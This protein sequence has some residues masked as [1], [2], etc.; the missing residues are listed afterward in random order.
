MKKHLAVLIA[1]TVALSAMTG[2]SCVFAENVP[3]YPPCPKPV[4]NVTVVGTRVVGEPIDL[5]DASISTNS[6]TDSA[7]KM[8]DGNITTYWHSKYTAEGST[9]TSHDVA[10]FCVELQLPKKTSISGIGYTPR[11]NNPAGYWKSL[12]V[13]YSNDGKKYTAICND[14]YEYSGMDDSR[15]ITGFGRNISAK[16]IRVIITETPIYC[17]A[18]EFHVFGPLASVSAKPT[19][20]TT[21]TADVTPGAGKVVLTMNSLSASV[22][23]MTQI[24]PVAPTIVGGATMVPLQ[25]MIEALGGAYVENGDDIQVAYNGH[26]YGLKKN[27]TYLTVDTMRSF[28]AKPT[29]DFHGTIMVSVLFF[30]NILGVKAELNQAQQAIVLMK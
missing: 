8:L 15:R 14:T 21:T 6:G 3:T 16:Y 27:S 12:Q 13:L 28:L 11:Q 4:A 19:V 5:S 26:T 18:A 7:I 9:I 24:L 29:L 30:A 25:Y 10:P 2:L 17:M 20:R 22:N 1:L 23:G